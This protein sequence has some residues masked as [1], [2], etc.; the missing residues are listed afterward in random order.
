MNLPYEIN[1][2]SN[3]VKRGLKIFIPFMIMFWVTTIAADKG[4]PFDIFD[5]LLIVILGISILVFI[6]RLDTVNDK[7]ILITHEFI[8]ETKG[9]NSIKIYWKENFQLYYKT[10]KY[11]FSGI[12]PI[13]G[14][15]K[16]QIITKDSRIIIHYFN[17]SFHEELIQLAH[18][19]LFDHIKKE[20]NNGARI[21]FGDLEIDS[22]KIYFR[23]NTVLFNDI[24]SIH[25]KS[26]YLMLKKRNNPI[27]LLILLKNTCNL[28]ILLKLLDAKWEKS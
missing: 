19:R 28:S 21:S 20:L 5:Y 3:P 1:I 16:T 2:A 22:N 10:D 9:K 25:L 15:K 8:Q 11:S 23:N 14:I 27:P 13:G 26:P 7:V 6:Y 4:F 12:F 17:S 18:F 24:K